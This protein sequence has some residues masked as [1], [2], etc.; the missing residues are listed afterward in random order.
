[1]NSSQ[2]IARGYAGR[3][4][5]FPMKRV[6][7]LF[8]YHPDKTCPLC[9]S[10]HV[11]RTKRGRFLEFWVLLLSCPSGPTDAESA[12]SVFTDQRNLPRLEDPDESDEPVGR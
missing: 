5:S 2:K 7:G 3:Y 1:M 11:H 6:L 9:G 4:H 8:V 10:M 12:G